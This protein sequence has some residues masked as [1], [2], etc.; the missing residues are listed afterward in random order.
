ME[1]RNCLPIALVGYKDDEKSM[2]FSQDFCS[3]TVLRLSDVIY[4]IPRYQGHIG[5]SILL[6]IN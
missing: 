4:K 5:A 6:R 3:P 2:I 1:R